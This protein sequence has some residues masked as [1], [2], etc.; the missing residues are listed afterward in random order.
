MERGA[1]VEPLANAVG[2]CVGNT[3]TR[4]GL[5]REGRLVESES[6]PNT[7]RDDIIAWARSKGGEVLLSSVNEPAAITLEEK[8][9]DVHR[10]GRDFDIPIR[11]DLHPDAT[12]GQDRLLCALG[13]WN[14][15][16]QACVVVDAGTAVTVDYV[17]A[18]GAFRGG[19]IA[20][21]LNMSLRALHEQTSALPLL[22]YDASALPEGP[23]GR[24]TA[25]AMREG[26]RAGIIGLV[27]LMIDRY[28][29]HAGSY[30]QVV[31]TGGDA[32]MLFENDELVEHIVPDLQLMGLWA[33][34]EGAG[35]GD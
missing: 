10:A 8:L 15:T 22:R 28:A 14:R 24:N 25:E 12:P 1:M 30:P 2:L 17:D 26:A 35:G 27:H 13:A 16:E 5:F 18:E 9:H 29:L 33:A 6:M 7:E 11:T 23:F 32:V 20:A 3:R 31:A 21:G 34:W 4:V 19:V